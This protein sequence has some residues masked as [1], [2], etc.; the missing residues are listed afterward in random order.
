[1]RVPQPI[2]VRDILLVSRNAEYFGDDRYEPGG[3]FPLPQIIGMSTISR[4][5]SRTYPAGGVNKVNMTLR[6]KIPF[7]ENISIFNLPVP[8]D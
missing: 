7:N 1:M 4:I 5:I 6:R 8:T 3:N 2:F